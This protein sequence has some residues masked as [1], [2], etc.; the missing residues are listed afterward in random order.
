MN[1]YTSEEKRK[2]LAQ[3]IAEGSMVLLKN[4]GQCLPLAE[5]ELAF[6]A[7]KI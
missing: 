3:H 1:P 7:E 5:G 4:K 6:L 2:Q